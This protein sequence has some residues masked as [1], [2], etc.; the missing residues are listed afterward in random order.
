[1]AIQR[2][3][4]NEFKISNLNT[5]FAYLFDPL[6]GQQSIIKYSD[7]SVTRD[8][9]NTD[10]YGE[11]IFIPSVDFTGYVEMWGA[12][13]GCH[14]H[15]NSDTGNTGGGGGYARSTIYF[16]KDI[17][18]CIV[19]GQGGSHTNNTIEG[20]N[21]FINHRMWQATI[22]GG[23][24][25][26]SSGGSGGG[27]S[28]IFYNSFGSIDYSPNGGNSRANSLQAS[29]LT[30]KR[31]TTYPQ[32]ANALLIAGGGGG[33]G[34]TGGANHGQ[35][36]GGGGTTSNVSHNTGSA[37]QT[38]GG[39][40]GYGGITGI[41]MLGG[42]AG[43][44]SSHTGGG[45]GGWFGGGGGGHTTG[46]HNGGSGG[47]GHAPD[48]YTGG[49][50]QHLRQFVANSYIETSPSVYVG[51]NASTSNTN[52]PA[53]ASNVRRNTTTGR[54]GGRQGSTPSPLYNSAYNIG[55]NGQIIISLVQGWS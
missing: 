46:H 45:G 17:P 26:H 41:A 37:S 35:A 44:G 39:A 28:G 1:L 11:Y 33:G 49:P 29:Q 23:G 48:L 50:N 24:Q 30:S 20:C 32:Q 47:S 51:S 14:S 53:Q 5:E 9:F 10:I 16:K 6:N 21:S 31:S 36:G 43:T 2:G 22:G 19:V 25:G 8:V 38:A 13:G 27:L 34:H 12:G 42:Q 15:A 4:N 55:G 3:R 18:Y 7:I 52:Q 40:G 54:G